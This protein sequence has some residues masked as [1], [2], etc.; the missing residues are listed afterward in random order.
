MFEKKSQKKAK[1]K[2]LL[3]VEDDA[4]LSRAL[5]D[6]FATENFDI[7]RVANGL[8]VQETVEKKIPDVILLDLILPGL[9]G[10]AVLKQLKSDT[11]TS[12]IPVVIVSNLGSVADV[13]SAKSLGAEAYFI[14]ANTEIEQIVEF[15]NKLV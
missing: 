7:I 1:Q 15:V 11:K 14:K 6:A 3:I 2:V 12:A 13:K 8:E 10:F 5:A 9:D 4:L